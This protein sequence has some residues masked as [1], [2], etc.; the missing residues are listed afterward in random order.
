LK[1]FE[2]AVELDN[3]FIQAY[4]NKAECLYQMKDYDEAA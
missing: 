3:Q 2:K 1:F 4:S